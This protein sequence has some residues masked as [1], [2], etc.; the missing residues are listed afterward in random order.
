MQ[1]GVYTV[2]ENEVSR[3]TRLKFSE[4][5]DNWKKIV[6]IIQR[7]VY[8]HWKNFIYESVFVT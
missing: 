5:F 7:C 8:L 3:K 6:Y 4:C 2:S 1:V